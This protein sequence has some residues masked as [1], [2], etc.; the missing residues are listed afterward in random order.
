MK[1]EQWEAIHV[2]I[3]KMENLCGQLKGPTSPLHP[4][5]KMGEADAGAQAEEGPPA[6]GA[7]SDIVGVRAEIRTQLDFLR[8][9][10][11]EQLAERDCYLVLFPIVAYF[12]EH[13]KT[14]YL[15]ENQLSWPPLQKELF[16]IDDAG[17]LF[18]ETVDEI[19]RKPQTIPFIYEVYYFCLNKGFQGKYVDNPV[20]INDYMKKLREKIPVAD[21]ES[22]DVVPED[23]GR[24]KAV[25]SAI[26]Y[27]AVPVVVLTVCYFLLRASADYLDLGFEVLGK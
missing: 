25:G 20:K 10:L 4:S 5:P 15:D 24:I 13:V 26:W 22:I 6:G 11:A 8:V 12:D 3:E 16:Q 21:P 9:K 1:N 23:T 18:Y 2:V 17:E 19:L 27:Y 7:L 14:S